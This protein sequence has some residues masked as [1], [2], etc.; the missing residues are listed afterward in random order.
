MDRC[1]SATANNRSSGPA[2]A[3]T[4]HTPLGHA[5]VTATI[6]SVDRPVWKNG[7]AQQCYD[8]RYYELLQRTLDGQ[9]EHR[10]LLLQDA[11]GTTRAI[12]PFFLVTQDLAAG[13]PRHIRKILEV[14]R[15]T[16]PNFL[17][18]KMLMVGCSV[19][20]SHL[21]DADGARTAWVSQLLHEVLPGVA[22]RFDAS[23]IVLKDFPSCYRTV[24]N[25]FSQNGYKR[26]PSMPGARLNLDYSSF[27]E[28]MTKS[29]SHAT[30]K[31]L[32]RKFRDAA[33][34]PRI[35]MQT[36]SDLT[37]YIDEIYPLYQQV[38]ARAENKF[39]ELTPSYFCELGRTLPD[40]V[41]IFI[42]RQS[43]KIVA[44]SVCLAHDGILHDGNIG[45]DYSVALDAH[46]YFLT[47]RDIVQ[48]AIENKFKTYYSG[49]ANYD[50]K[51]HLR[52]SLVPLDLYARHTSSWINPVFRR[53]LGFLEP[54]RYDPVI[55]RFANFHE[56][57]G[58]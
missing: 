6:P 41:R 23:L 12:Q 46:L 19:G 56:L 33:R 7:F 51:L 39:E 49:P 30:R 13:L 4:V 32:R 42:W 37:P 21:A 15:N 1:L 5:T 26:I 25:E 50:P 54:T 17:K 58:C 35:E 45:L 29:L 47:W 31:N 48:W 44:F 57:W 8:H 9:F 16:A 10:Y 55:R 20:E 43:E 28:Y 52:L 38:L 27:E 40:R 22:K 53:I 24:L 18:L 34:L 14:V 3:P 36:V 11:D 2:E